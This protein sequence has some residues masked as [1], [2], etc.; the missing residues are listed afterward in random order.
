MPFTRLSD[1][2]NAILARETV[3]HPADPGNGYSDITSGDR[4]SIRRRYL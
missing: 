2:A 4:N 3:T 1:I